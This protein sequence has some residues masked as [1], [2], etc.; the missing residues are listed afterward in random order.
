MVSNSWVIVPAVSNSMGDFQADLKAFSSNK[1]WAI[2]SSNFADVLPPISHTNV[3][4]ISWEIPANSWVIFPE[5]SWLIFL[6]TPGHFS[7]AV[8]G[9]F[10]KKA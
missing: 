2:Y 6:F 9:N 4:T 1:L 8:E 5:K 3:P 7:Y 10:G